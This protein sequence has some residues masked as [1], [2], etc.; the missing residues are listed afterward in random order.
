M[1]LK[2]YRCLFRDD[3]ALP[4]PPGRVRMT[5]FGTTT[6]LLDDGETQMLLD[7]QLTRPNLPKILFGRLE[8]D[9]ALVDEVLRRVSMERLRAIFVSH[10]HYDHVLDAAYLAARTGAELFGSRSAVNVGLGGGV[11][12]ERLHAFAAG[13]TYRVGA[14]SVTILPSV[15][16]KPNF[17]NDDLGVEIPAPLR[18][19]A[20]KR[21]YSEGGSFDFLIR[22]GAQ[23]LLVRPSCNY[24]PG[25]LRDVR[26]E[27]MLLGIGVMGKETPEFMDAF[28]RE[29]VQTVDAKRLIPIHWDNF[30][31]PLRAPLRPQTRLGDNVPRSLD[32][33]LARCAAEGRILELA[34]AFSSVIL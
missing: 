2:N 34:D 22:R 4:L 29:T 25:A 15:H 33:L 27:T 16:S 20:R 30:F 5:F 3:T 31:T 26:A 18:Q 13:E 14:F 23:S 8:T 19:P 24:I 9:A 32:F 11:P 28:W 6:W 12:V 1:P 7:A 10:T 21:D 17:L